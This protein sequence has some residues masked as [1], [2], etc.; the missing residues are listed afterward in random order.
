MPQGLIIS[1]QKFI[2]CNKIASIGYSDREEMVN[3]I[4]SKYLP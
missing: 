3:H 4:T 1:K 2:I